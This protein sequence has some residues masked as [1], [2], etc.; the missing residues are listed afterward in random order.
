MP[1]E[2]AVFEPGLIVD[3]SYELVAPVPG[4]GLVETWTARD[5]NDDA[6]TFSLKLLRATEGRS[7]PRAFTDRVRALV[8][9]RHEALVATQRHGVWRGRAYLVQAPVTG[10]PLTEYL[11]TRRARPPTFA[12]AEIDTLF[13]QIANAVS[14]AH[15][16]ATPVVHGDLQPRVV[17]VHDTH[18]GAPSV[19]VMDF[20]VASLLDPSD[21]WRERDYVA[22]EHDPAREPLVAEDVFALGKILRLL[23]EAPPHK[24]HALTFADGFRGRTDVPDAVWRVVERATA[25]GAQHRHDSVAA[26]TTELEAAWRQ[27][28][29]TP[30]PEVVAPPPRVPVPVAPPSTPPP[31][32]PLVEHSENPW[33]TFVR[34]RITDAPQDGFL[35]A[36]PFDA[37]V[38]SGTEV[39]SGASFGEC[40]VN[41]LPAEG[42][43]E[44]TFLVPARAPVS[45]PQPPSWAPLPTPVD[46]H[47]GDDLAAT[48]VMRGAPLETGPAPQPVETPPLPY[49]AKSNVWVFVLAAAFGALVALAFIV[50]WALL[51]RR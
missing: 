34:N 46:P 12:L 43:I 14:A 40:V 3:A 5:P 19:R 16:A 25:A 51:L 28:V 13:R 39:A 41:T 50:A 10:V 9:L 38:S 15:R 42:A 17:L 48:M 31:S 30:P 27:P 8:M 24:A 35:A 29:H 2:P 20:G 44:E 26:L 33:A 37:E 45:S 22:P 4:V 6:R 23:L 11:L 1:P 7:L 36:S 21:A 18:A 47:D 49:A 32:Q